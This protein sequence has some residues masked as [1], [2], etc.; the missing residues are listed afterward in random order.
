M[1]KNHYSLWHMAPRYWLI[2]SYRHEKNRKRRIEP[3]T[4]DLVLRIAQEAG[5][6]DLDVQEYPLIN[7]SFRFEGDDAL[8]SPVRQA[9][10]EAANSAVAWVTGRLVQQSPVTEPIGN[11]PPTEFEKAYYCQLEESADTV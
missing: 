4:G 9:L 2:G 7:Q 10:R 11:I 3:D 6:V 1:Q 5:L 8:C